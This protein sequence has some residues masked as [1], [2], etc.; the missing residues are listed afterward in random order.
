MRE[1]VIGLTDAEHERYK[2]IATVQ[3][4]SIENLA[5]RGLEN[6][7]AVLG[8]FP[9]EEL[10]RWKLPTIRGARETE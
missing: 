1:L 9:P 10:A 3:G 2:A 5:R 6:E 8:D 4:I 7:R